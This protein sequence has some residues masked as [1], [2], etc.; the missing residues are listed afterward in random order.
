MRKLFSYFEHIENIILLLF[1]FQL[2]L[3]CVRSIWCNVLCWKKQQTFCS[4]VYVCLEILSSVV[5][6]SPAPDLF[7]LRSKVSNLREN[8]KFSLNIFRHSAGLPGVL[9]K[10]TKWSVGRVSRFSD[11]CSVWKRITSILDRTVPQSF[12]ELL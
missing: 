2:N 1:T 12:A 7:Y 6:V 10:I 11:P 4:A 8:R 3:V 9:A 5:I